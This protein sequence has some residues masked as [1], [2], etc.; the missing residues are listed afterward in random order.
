MGTLVP[1]L[2]HTHQYPYPQPMVGNQYPC[3]SLN[4]IH[5]RELHQYFTI[6]KIKKKCLQGE[7]RHQISHMHCKDSK[8][9]LRWLPLV[10]RMPVMV[11]E[12][13]LIH[14]KVVNS[15][16]GVV[17]KIIYKHSD[18]GCKAVCIHVNV[19]SSLISI[20]GLAP[21]VVPIF[22]RMVSF[23]CRLCQG[24]RIKIS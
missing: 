13:L 17:D 21:G 15:S 8:E 7:W 4:A 6:N 3:L 12:N 23:E 11:T 1:T 18:K 2:T 16:E 22:P 24:V 19:Q 9:A 20:D 5:V 10:I 14:N